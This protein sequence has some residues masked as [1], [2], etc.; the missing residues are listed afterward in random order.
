M[1]NPQHLNRPVPMPVV[2]L[3]LTLF[4]FILMLMGC[5]ETD[6]LA[7]QVEAAQA[8]KVPLNAYSLNDW[9]QPDCSVIY[10]DC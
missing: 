1:G 5:S 6:R 8:D 4:P 10:S 7:A 9:P 2:W 3:A